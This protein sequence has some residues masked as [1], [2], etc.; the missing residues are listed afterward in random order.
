[1]DRLPE[2]STRPAPEGRQRGKLMVVSG[3]PWPKLGKAIDGYRVFVRKH[4]KA[5]AYELFGDLAE[6]DKRI[7]RLEDRFRYVGAPMAW[8]PLGLFCLWVAVETLKNAGS[9]QRSQR[10]PS[11]IE[12]CR[13][14]L[15]CRERH[16][17]VPK[18]IASPNKHARGNII[19]YGWDFDPPDD[20]SAAALL[21]RYWEAD[22]L[23]RSVPESAGIVLDEERTAKLNRYDKFETARMDRIQAGFMLAW[24]E[25]HP[26]S[27][28][29]LK[30]RG[31]A[32]SLLQTA[33]R[34]ERRV[35]KP[36]PN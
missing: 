36:T 28:E 4:G 14:L 11:L 34:L 33:A 10:R 27:L 17:H 7:A 23:I 25:S 3:P 19:I 18:I 35:R 32:E 29:S 8:S 21:R 6:V 1:M 26:N 9:E 15:K 31:Y 20:I 30:W 5:V 16:W 22:G 2:V 24:I 13:R 12:I